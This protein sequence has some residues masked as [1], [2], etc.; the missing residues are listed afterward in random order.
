[1]Q[2]M[3]VLLVLAVLVLAAGCGGGASTGTEG[4]DVE[5]ATSSATTSETTTPEMTT[6]ETTAVEPNGKCTAAFAKYAQAL[7]NNPNVSEGRFQEAIINLCSH[8]EWLTAVEGYTKGAN[9]IACVNPERVLWAMCGGEKDT[10]QACEGL[11][12]TEPPINE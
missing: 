4:I 10:A 9:C 1:M 12:D 7:E 8:D 5:G 11:P 6:S 3:R 2:A